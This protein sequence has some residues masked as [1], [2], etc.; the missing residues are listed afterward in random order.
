ML[1][2]TFGAKPHV[3]DTALDGCC[4]QSDIEK[5]EPAGVGKLSYK[6]SDG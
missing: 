2:Q 3:A 6:A 1:M 4:M 5:G